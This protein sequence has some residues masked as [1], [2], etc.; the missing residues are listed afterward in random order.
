MQK[1]KKKDPWWPNYDNSNKDRMSSNSAVQ[2]HTGAW[3]KKEKWVMP[4]LSL[5]KILIFI[6]G[7]AWLFDNSDF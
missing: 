6:F 3:G 5:F 2:S 7:S 1:K 4:I